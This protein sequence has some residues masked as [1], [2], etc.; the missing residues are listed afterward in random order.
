[1]EEDYSLNTNQSD[2]ENY[3]A[4]NHKPH[5]SNIEATKTAEATWGW[6]KIAKIARKYDEDKVKDCKEDIDTL[7]VFAGLFSAVVTAFIIEAYQNLQANPPDVS[8]QVLVQ[9]SQQLYSITGVQGFGN[10]STS[11][12]TTASSSSFG[13]T[14]AIHVSSLWFA[15]LVCSLM[16]A[17]LGILVKQ[18]L[19]EYMAHDHLSPRAYIR[20]RHRRQQ[21]IVQ[22]R[23]FEIAAVLPLILQLSLGLFFAGLAYFM[24]VISPT[25]GKVVTTLV[26][27]WLALFL[28][29]SLAP[30]VFARCPYKTPLFKRHLASLRRGLLHMQRLFWFVF[31]YFGDDQVIRTSTTKPSLLEKGRHA[32][33]RILKKVLEV[34]RNLLFITLD[35]TYDFVSS[36]NHKL[37][38]RWRELP[39]ISIHDEF[40]EASAH[41]QVWLDRHAIVAMDATFSD[42][43]F[44]MILEQ[45]LSDSSLFTVHKWIQSL[46][47]RRLGFRFKSFDE[48]HSTLLVGENLSLTTLNRYRKIMAN[49]IMLEHTK[50]LRDI[51]SSRENIPIGFLDDGMAFITADPPPIQG[52][53]DTYRILLDWDKAIALRLILRFGN[54]QL[55]PMMYLGPL[56]LSN[57]GLRN[58][59]ASI[60][61]IVTTVKPL[62]TGYPTAFDEETIKKISIELHHR[63]D[64]NES[65]NTRLSSSLIRLALNLDCFYICSVLLYSCQSTSTEVLKA[66]LSNMHQV[67]A[68]VAKYFEVEK[69]ALPNES[70]REGFVNGFYG[71]RR[72][73]RGLEEKHD[74]SEGVVHHT[75]RNFLDNARPFDRS[76]SMESDIVLPGQ[77]HPH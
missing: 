56:K 65:R 14:Q 22:Y 31:T 6:S 72:V 67:Q 70:V 24:L 45:C 29:T 27:L 28:S 58:I 57:R 75:L 46:V 37:L 74:I 35:K 21:G 26:S 39:K 71:L 16:T 42:D 60:E 59:L 66:N 2:S 18:W 7:L 48:L 40:D 69:E 19:R 44:G 25:V 54:N 11:S 68:T 53:E 63:K 41:S 33:S 55:R 49:A 4:C 61:Y 50:H 15:S 36:K 9:I 47:T 34:P 76:S 43:H 17:S 5:V 3:H 13:T 20:V 10:T 23:V 64:M 30:A 73:L 62:R 32:A 77:G 51:G 8:A 52:F 12:D 38:N 1:M